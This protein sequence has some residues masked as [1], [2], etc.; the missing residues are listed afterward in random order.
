MAP[1]TRVPAGASRSPG[2]CSSAPR[3][4]RPS[5]TAFLHDDSNA[6]FIAGQLRAQ[7]YHEDAVANPLWEAGNAAFRYRQHIYEKNA[8]GEVGR[9]SS[10]TSEFGS[11]EQGRVD[12][13]LALI[14]ERLQKDPF[15]TPYHDLF[16]DIIYDLTSIRM[17][18]AQEALT[19]LDLTRI[20]PPPVGGQVIDNE[21]ALY[22]ASLPMLRDAIG[23]MLESL[24]ADIAYTASGA[25]AGYEFFKTRVPLRPLMPATY[26]DEGTVKPLNDLT[27]APITESLIDGYRDALLFF[28]MLGEY[29]ASA[30]ELAKLYRLTDRPADAQGLLRNAR[31]LVF[32][33]GSVIRGIFRDPATGTDPAQLEQALA[34]W[35]QGISDLK[36]S[37]DAFDTGLNPLGFDDDFLVLL[38]RDDSESSDIFNTFDIL[39]DRVIN[40]N[41]SFLSDALDDQQAA[42]DDYA[43]YRSGLD[44]LQI[45]LININDGA[46]LRLA[47][48]VGRETTHPLYDEVPGSNVGAY[49]GFIQGSEMANQFLNIRRARL[50]ILRNGQEMANIEEKVRIEVER[51]LFEVEKQNA[52]A[53]IRIDYA[54]QRADMETEISQLNAAQKYTEVPWPRPPTQPTGHRSGS[55]PSTAASRFTGSCAKANSPPSAS[56]WPRKRKPPSSVPTTRSSTPTAPHSLL[57]GCST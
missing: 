40:D 50:Q 45:G 3:S 29:G 1:Q 31:E 48:I 38:Q 18:Q 35:E 4:S 6:T 47:Q 44:E 37:E 54:G 32:L 33:Q 49:G 15:G 19:G 25:P 34:S 21:I 27:G 56:A 12:Q 53:D 16:L 24:D 9:A 30:A 57:R 2:G 52:I 36:G 14:S 51:N 11:E 39:E 17:I 23:T 42:I 10:P 26:L 8:E 22:E 13:V 46:E 20:G 55:T 5:F 43:T 7:L 28:Q 41:R